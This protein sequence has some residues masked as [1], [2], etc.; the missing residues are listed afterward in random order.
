LQ[1]HDG[2]SGTSKYTVM[3]KLEIQNQG[4]YEK[5]N[6]GIV[7]DIFAEE[8]PIGTNAPIFDCHLGKAC[9]IP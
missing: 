6:N 2:I 8:Y 7:K 9:K 5:V 3:D 1:H 4:L